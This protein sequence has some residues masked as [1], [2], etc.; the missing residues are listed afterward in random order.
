MRAYAC[1]IIFISSKFGDF[2]RFWQEKFGDNIHNRQ[3]KFGDFI[4]FSQKN[5]G[6]Y[7]K[8][9]VFAT[10]IHYQHARVSSIQTQ[11]LQQDASMEART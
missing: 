9:R 10:E 5:A 8:M 1:A 2:I 6:I 7:K 4:H 11:D 3:N